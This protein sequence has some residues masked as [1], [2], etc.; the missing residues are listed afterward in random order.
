M[1]NWETNQ[2]DFLKMIAEGKVRQLLVLLKP[3]YNRLIGDAEDVMTAYENL[4][5][6]TEIDI[7][8]F[9]LISSGHAWN[10]PPNFFQQL[11]KPTG[12]S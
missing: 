6:Q 12:N 5:T 10:L 9:A 11:N 2:D 8:S 3:Y 7:F 1:N 4:E